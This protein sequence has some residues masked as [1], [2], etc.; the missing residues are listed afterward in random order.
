MVYVQMTQYIEKSLRRTLTPYIGQITIILAVNIYAYPWPWF[1]GDWTLFYS[2]FLV[3]IFF[4]IYV[5]IA[6]RYRIYWC[7]KTIRRKASG[8]PD[9]IIQISDIAEV[10]RERATASE[11]AAQSAPFRRIKISDRSGHY[12]NISLRHFRVEDI[13]ELMC[14]VHKCRPDLVMP[15]GFT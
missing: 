3:W 7:E 1:K 5:Y 6:T 12:I 13:H 10:I 14:W 8:G 15:K 2:S 9:A 11:M 4:A